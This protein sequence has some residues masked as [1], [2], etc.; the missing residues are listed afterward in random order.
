MRQ[1]RD[2]EGGDNRWIGIL[3]NNLGKHSDYLG[4]YIRD[5]YSSLE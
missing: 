3:V 4:V 1:T 2:Y 5:D